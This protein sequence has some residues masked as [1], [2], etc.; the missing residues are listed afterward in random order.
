MRFNRH[1]NLEGM[2]SFL[3]AS[4]PHWVNYTDERLDQVYG[5][6]LAAQ[7]GTQMHKLAHDLIKMKVKL[8]RTPATINQYVNDAIGFRMEPEVMLVYSL[9]AFGTADAIS[10]RLNKE[11]DRM[12][13]RIH[14]LKNGTIPGKMIQLRIYAAYFCLEYE[15]NPTEFDIHLAIYQNDAIETEVPDPDEIRAIMDKIISHDKRINARREEAFG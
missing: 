11:T 14:D 9:N 4:K 15:Q 12:L 1:S 2:H 8:P 3:S 6:H 7:R 10:F 13:L 5:T